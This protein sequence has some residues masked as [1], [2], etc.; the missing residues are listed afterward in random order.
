M[1]TIISNINSQNLINAMNW[2]YATKSF[3]ENRKISEQDWQILEK[4]LIL[5]P[6]SFGLQPYKFIIVKNNKIRDDLVVHSWN[7]SQINKSSHLV[8]F[9][10]LNNIS[11]EYIDNF[12][13]L[14][15]KTRNIDSKYLE[16]YKK[17]MINN[18]IDSKKEIFNWAS[19]Q[20]YIALGN[21]MLSASLLEIDSCPIE[22]IDNQAYDNI[23]NL[24][25]SDY[26]T[27]CVCCLGFRSSDDKYQNLKKV[28]F[29]R[30]MLFQEI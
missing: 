24:N 18:L 22:G 3:D 8:V 21:L 23:L 17:M 13:Q 7:Q 6:S 10:A 26:K 15:A 5:S 4:S 19:K 27:S 11:E 9:T 1:S 14:T 16:D 29:S 28:R 20:A 12:I 25:N 2:R 30:E